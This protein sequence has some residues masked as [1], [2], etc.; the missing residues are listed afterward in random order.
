MYLQSSM[1]R[2]AFGLT[3]AGIASAA[4]VESAS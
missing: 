4:V 2:L 3:V 1:K